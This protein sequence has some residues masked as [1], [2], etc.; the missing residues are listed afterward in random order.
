MVIQTT[1]PEPPEP[2]WADDTPHATSLDPTGADQSDAEHPPTDL[3]VGG[4]SPSRRAPDQQVYRLS[5]LIPV[6][7]EVAPALKL[8]EE[9]PGA[10]RSATERLSQSWALRLDARWSPNFR[11]L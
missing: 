8:L 5:L 9:L 3:A 7:P 11:S 6:A 4:S 2:N 10:S 1:Q